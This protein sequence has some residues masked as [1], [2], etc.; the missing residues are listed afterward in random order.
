M[1]AIIFTGI[2]IRNLN[3]YM[4]AD[5]MNRS[6]LQVASDKFTHLLCPVALK[7]PNYALQHWKHCSDSQQGWL[8]LVSHTVWGLGDVYVWGHWR[9]GHLASCWWSCEC[10]HFHS[11]L[12]S[13]GTTGGGHPW[14][15]LSPGC[16]HLQSWC[17]GSRNDYIKL[18]WETILWW[19]EMGSKEGW[20]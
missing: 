4:V 8:W 17:L 19:E 13:S 1:S 3:K 16:P 6:Y 12:S 14:L 9:P 20:L 5:E 11:Q 7:F 10:W 15:T 18:I 2:V